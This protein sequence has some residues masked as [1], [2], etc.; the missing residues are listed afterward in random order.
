MIRGGQAV[1]C[2][3]LLF[4]SACSNSGEIGPPEIAY[5]EVECQRCRMIV[6]DER[7]ASVAQTQ[8][9]TFIFDDLGCLVDWHHEQ[10]A[11]LDAVWVHDEAS[12][13]WL[14]LGDVQFS[15]LP[16]RIT[17]MGSGLAAHGIPATGPQDGLLAWDD[18]RS[19]RRQ[20]G[21]PGQESAAEQGS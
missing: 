15:H 8:N 12:R 9:D 18:V 11:A 1:F 10:G 20:G 17:P 19:A 2:G 4:L 5:G 13:A 14:P 7:Y 21:R 6:S 3:L 16:D